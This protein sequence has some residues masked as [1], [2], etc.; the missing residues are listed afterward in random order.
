MK[1]PENKPIEAYGPEH[2]G[3]TIKE[4]INE[5]LNLFGFR[6]GFGTNFYSFTDGAVYVNEKS[7]TTSNMDLFNARQKH[8]NRFK[9]VLYKMMYSIMF[10]QKELGNYN[11]N[12][13]LDYE[14]IIDDSILED[15]ATLIERHI[16]FAQNGWI[17]IWKA[18]TKA[19]NISEEEAR[20][21]YEERKEDE[22]AAFNSFIQPPQEDEEENP[23]EE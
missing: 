9:S 22:D 23:E 8:V 3:L 13:D 12:L 1:M 18:L 2:N 4:S 6:C 20:M 7:V 16:T 10:L 15:D 11:G 21:L 17:P 5:H 14:V 19:L